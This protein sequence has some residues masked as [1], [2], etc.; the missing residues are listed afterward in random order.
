[1]ERETRII[2]PATRNLSNNQP[3]EPLKWASR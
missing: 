3:L 1:M 2:K